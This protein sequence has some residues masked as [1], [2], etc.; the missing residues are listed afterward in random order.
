M[1]AQTSLGMTTSINNGYILDISY[2]G[3]RLVLE[4][5]LTA[6]VTNINVGV[7]LKTTG[8]ERDMDLNAKI[9]MKSALDDSYPEC[10]FAYG[11]EFF[12]MD[13][14]DEMF[15]RAFC[16]LEINR[17]KALLCLWN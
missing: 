6:M 17:G 8:I 9:S 10:R 1:Q 7:K 15:L 14:T 12:E 2:H 11:V 4:K 13:P 5:E 3:A 16:L